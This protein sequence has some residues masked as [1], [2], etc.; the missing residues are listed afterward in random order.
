VVRNL[1]MSHERMVALTGGRVSRNYKE[2]QERVFPAIEAEAKANKTKVPHPY[3]SF[4]G[5]QAAAGYKRDELLRAMVSCAEADLALKF[6][7]DELVLERLVWTLCGRARAWESAFS[8]IR[9]ELE[10]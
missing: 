7:G 5:M 8:T 2:F 4:M 6:G 1:L 3:A 9:R 10:R